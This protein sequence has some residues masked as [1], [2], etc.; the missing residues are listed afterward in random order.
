ML[1]RFR[2]LI[3]GVLLAALL[4]A[5]AG[6]QSSAAPPGNSAV[7]QYR[8]SVPKPDGPRRSL[9]QR[10][11]SELRRLGPDGAALAATIERQGGVSAAETGSAPNAVERPNGSR[12]RATD[13]QD[14]ASVDEKTAAGAEHRETPSSDDR[15]VVAVSTSAVGDQLPLGWMAA[16]AALLAAVGI[17]RWRR[18]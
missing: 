5:T 3:L 11:R 13:R 14:P 9:S 12:D 7:D 10:E 1:R 8:E 4:P 18:A 15:G 17:I 16:I 6:A 2:V